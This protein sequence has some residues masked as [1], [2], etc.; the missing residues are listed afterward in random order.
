M[1]RHYVDN[2]RPTLAVLLDDAHAP[3]ATTVRARRGGD[4]VARDELHGAEAAHLRP[5]DLGVAHGA[6]TPQ[7][8]EQ[9]ARDAHTR[10]TEPASAGPSSLVLAAAELARLESATSAIAVVTGAPASRRAVADGHHLRSRARVIV[11]V[12]D[13]DRSATDDAYYPPLRA[14]LAPPC[15]TCRHSTSSAPDGTGSAD[16]PLAAA[17]AI[18]GSGGDR[19]SSPPHRR[20]ACTAS[21]TTGR[22]SGRPCSAR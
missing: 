20:S 7:G 16:E 12:V 17:L 2:R 6:V 19:G 9:H 13:R 15:S 22:S 21:P 18:V 14:R 4:D 11:I 1:V 10:G 8:R 3:Y 5:F